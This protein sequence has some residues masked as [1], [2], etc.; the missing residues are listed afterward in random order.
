MLNTTQS[1]NAKLVTSQGGFEE[2]PH[3]KRRYKK[4]AKRPH[5]TLSPH[6]KRIYEALKHYGNERLYE[7]TLLNRKIHAKHFNALF[8]RSRRLFEISPHAKNCYSQSFSRAGYVESNSHTKALR[9]RMRWITVI[10]SVEATKEAALEK[11]FEL[12]SMLKLVLKRFRGL[13]MIGSIEVEMF[14]L[15]FALAFRRHFFETGFSPEIDK[16][17]T[18]NDCESLTQRQFRKLDNCIELATRSGFDPAIE[19]CAV[20]LVHFHGLIAPI[21]DEQLLKVRTALNGV[22]LWSFNPRQVQL[23]K[24]HSPSKKNRRLL[25]DEIR[26]CCKYATKMGRQLNGR[27][28]YLKYNLDAPDGFQWSL[29]GSD[30][31]DQSMN[32]TPFEINEIHV[33]TDQLMNSSKQGN[34]HIVMINNRSPH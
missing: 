16:A 21:N 13:K 18:E 11:C 32:L 31:S 26:N 10:H 1:S 14:P 9:G 25:V 27:Y 17:S 29:L 7:T 24:M 5:G 6:E 19:C 28:S 33:L 2:C 4:R 20:F 3:K 22:A 12:K 34:G 8:A 15:N 30:F 23:K